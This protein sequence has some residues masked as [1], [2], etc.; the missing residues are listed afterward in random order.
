MPGLFDNALAYENQ[1]RQ[2]KESAKLRQALAAYQAQTAFQRMMAQ[3]GQITSRVQN[4]PGMQKVQMARQQLADKQKQDDATVKWVM[5]LDPSKVEPQW[6]YYLGQVQKSLGSN[7]TPEVAKLFT[8]KY[9]PAGLQFKSVQT[10]M[11]DGSGN[12]VPVTSYVVADP[13]S[14]SLGPAGMA[15]GLSGSSMP[16]STGRTAAGSGG[17]GLSPSAAALAKKYGLGGGP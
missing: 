12:M 1:D 2:M 11:D 10:M 9:R 6:R 3:Q 13:M 4:G 5:G 14:G 8:S 16:G 7:P 17:T 15:P